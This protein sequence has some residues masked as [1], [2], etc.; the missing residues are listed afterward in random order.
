MF[1]RWFLG[2]A[3]ASLLCAQTAPAGHWEGTFNADG[4]EIGISFDLAQKDAGWIASMGMPAENI[5]GLVVK[6]LA[7][8]GKSVKFMAVEMMMSMVD[9]KLGEYGKLTGTI[10]NPRSSLPIEFHRTGEAKVQLPPTSPAVSKELEGDWA[11]AL[12]T[13]GSELEVTIHFKNLPDGTVSATIDI[14]ATKSVA[15]PIDHVKQSGDRVE[16][17]LKIAHGAFQGTLKGAELTGELGHDGQSMPMVL[18]KK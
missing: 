18:K 13:P 16:F 10:A 6:D 1:Y 15:M 9:L 5:T 4:R 14:P 2:L 7:V 12:K 8:N 17:G 11:G 3:A